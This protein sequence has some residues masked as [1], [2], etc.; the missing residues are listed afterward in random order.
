MCSV[1]LILAQTVSY[2]FDV[3]QFLLGTTLYRCVVAS[4]GSPV[5]VTS[6]SS[7]YY[8]WRSVQYISLK[9]PC[10]LMA[11][12][13]PGIDLGSQNFAKESHARTEDSRTALTTCEGEMAFPSGGLPFA[14][15]GS[16]EA[17]TSTSFASYPIPCTRAVHTR[18][19]T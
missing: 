1:G 5:V 11:R 3:A 8:T 17:H 15:K 4:S 13:V 2:H 16:I 10:T 19:S 18:K 9:I 7:W 12:T 14:T 6:M